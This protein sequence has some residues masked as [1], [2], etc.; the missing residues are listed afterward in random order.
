M[1][2]MYHE[3][4]I[5][6]EPLRRIFVLKRDPISLLTAV[7]LTLFLLRGAMAGRASDYPTAP[8]WF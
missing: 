8:N 7:L 3:D 6:K 5:T 1:S 4:R 2:L